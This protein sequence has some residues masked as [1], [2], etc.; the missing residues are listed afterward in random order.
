MTTEQ[1]SDREIYKILIWTL[2]P[3]VLSTVIYNIG[4]V[5]DQGVFNAIL[6]GRAIPRNSM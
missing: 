6:A 4:T 2:V 5:L 1:E 3:I